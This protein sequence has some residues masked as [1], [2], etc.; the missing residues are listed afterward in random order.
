M[1]GFVFKTR[2]GVDDPECPSG[3]CKMDY[4]NGFDYWV[5]L[6]NGIHACVQEDELFYNGS[7]LAECLADG[8]VVLPD[9]EAEIRIE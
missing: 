1:D 4:F 6:S 2:G 7:P 3:P 9:I 8:R 5:V